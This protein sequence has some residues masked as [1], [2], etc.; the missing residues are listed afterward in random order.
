MKL[1][2]SILSAGNGG[3]MRQI[4]GQLGITPAQAASATSA[5]LPAI[6]AGA[7]EK[8]ASGG[9]MAFAD[10]I[11]SP[12]LSRFATDPTSLGTPA[13]VY[14]GESLLN[15]IFGNGD[16]SGI[17]SAVAEKVRISSSVVTRMLPIAATMLGAFLSKSANSGEGDMTEQLGEIASAGDSDVLGVVRDVTAKVLR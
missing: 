5:L 9:T 17:A 11:S 10:L 12:N 3:F 2:D 16:L 1:L 7:Q 8:L 6:A 14:Q 4:A 13:A 15:H